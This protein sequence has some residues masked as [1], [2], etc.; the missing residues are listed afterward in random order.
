MQWHEVFWNISAVLIPQVQQKIQELCSLQLTPEGKAVKLW[1]CFVCFFTLWYNKL[2]RKRKSQLISLQVLPSKV[3][4]VHW[5]ADGT[6]C[7]T[8]IPLHRTPSAFTNA[9]S[10]QNPKLTSP[11]KL[12][13]VKNYCFKIVQQGDFKTEAI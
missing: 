2:K 12:F 8:I 6:R 1:F 5:A 7:H 4:F 11:Q 3:N 13:L 10:W 9:F